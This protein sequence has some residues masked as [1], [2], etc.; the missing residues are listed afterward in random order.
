VPPVE[1]V[2][3]VESFSRARTNLAAHAV[4]DAVAAATACY[5]RWSRTAKPVASAAVREAEG[6]MQKPGSGE[7]P[8]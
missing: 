4:R 5:A 1:S 3:R 8:G 2:V 6:V 7:G